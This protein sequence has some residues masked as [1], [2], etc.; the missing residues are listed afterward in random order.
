LNGILVVDKPPDMMSAKIVSLVKSFLKADKAGHAGTLD[1]FATGVMVCLIN[2]A[3]RLA[4]FF[5]HGNKAYSATLYLGIETDTQDFTGTVLQAREIGPG[6]YSSDDIRLAFRSF[7]GESRQVPSSFSAL[8]HQGKPLYHYARQGVRV[9]KPSRP[10]HVF[11]LTVEKIDL[12][13]IHFNVRC[14]GGTYVRALC[15]DIGKR[16]GC[17]AHLTAL[18]R[19]EACGFTLSDAMTLNEVESLAIAGKVTGRLISMNDALRHMPV[20]VADEALAERVR[21][22]QRLAGNIFPDELNAD[23]GGYFKLVDKTDRLLAVIQKQ[24]ETFRYCCVFPE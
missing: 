20:H 14:S 5:L 12:P 23:N 21:Y 19:T 7:E 13:L 22:G 15:D 3:T 1:P 8:K 16:L 10:I 4:E 9:E 11:S 18:R 24:D 2:R 17:G 6:D